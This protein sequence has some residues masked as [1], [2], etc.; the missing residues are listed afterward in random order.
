MKT[1]D[2]SVN[3]KHYYW[4]TIKDMEEDENVRKKNLEVVDFVKENT[5]QGE[6]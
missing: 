6:N 2:F 1:D 5:N 4:M 3:G